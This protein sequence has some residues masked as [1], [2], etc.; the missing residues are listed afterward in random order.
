[1]SNEAEFSRIY[2]GKVEIDENAVAEF[3]QRRAQSGAN[4]MLQ[5]QGSNLPAQR[6]QH[7]KNLILSLLGVKQG[8]KILDIG[9]GTGRWAAAFIEM[10]SISVELLGIDYV[11]EHIDTC[12]TKYGH[13]FRFQQMSAAE[14][15][16]DEL[17][18]PPPFDV[19]L[20]NG[21][22]VYLNDA[23]CAALVQMLPQLAAE[24]STIYLRESVSLLANRL[25]LKEFYS[26]ELESSYNAIYRTCDEYLQMIETVL[27]PAGFT[28]S[29]QDRLLHD[30]LANR[31]ETNQYYWLLQ[32]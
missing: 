17:L 26:E 2:G 16:P 21:L 31:K 20:I 11:Q 15:V 8:T 5:A 30:Q 22:M 19:V 24:Q 6:D 12:E 3:W 1:M 23:S 29:Q 10:D 4:T 18:I 32:R 13:K 9:C 7:E 28:I 25:T 14:I 27:T